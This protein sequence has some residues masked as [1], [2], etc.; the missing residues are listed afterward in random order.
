M[1]TWVAAIPEDALHSARVTPMMSATSPPESA[2]VAAWWMAC[3]SM[4]AALPGRAVRTAESIPDT[5]DGDALT[6]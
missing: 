4:V 6:I 1:P 2:R 3:V 5:R